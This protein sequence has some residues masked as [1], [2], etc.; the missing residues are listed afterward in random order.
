MD[1]STATLPAPPA[2]EPAIVPLAVDGDVV[3]EGAPE[4]EQVLI[5]PPPPAPPESQETRLRREAK[6]VLH[7]MTHL[8]MNEFCDFCREGKL[9]PATESD[10]D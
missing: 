7:L 3:A 10:D 5:V 1:V 2:A 4:G 8:P 9:T 6:T